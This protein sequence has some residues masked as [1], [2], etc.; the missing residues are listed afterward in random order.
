MA[1][2]I[3]VRHAIEGPRHNR[4]V[5]AVIVNVDSN[6]VE[7][8]RRRFSQILSSS[9]SIKVAVAYREHWGCEEEFFAANIIICTAQRATS[10]FNWYAHL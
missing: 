5:T 4:R 1:N 6:T 9:G 2:L 8:T 3:A 10:I 7:A